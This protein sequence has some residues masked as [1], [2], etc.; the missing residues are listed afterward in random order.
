MLLMMIANEWTY[1]SSQF[2]NEPWYDRLWNYRLRIGKSSE[3]RAADKK[4]LHCTK[5]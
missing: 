3:I 4:T 1:L 2:G 5:R